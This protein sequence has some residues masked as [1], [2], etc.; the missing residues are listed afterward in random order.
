MVKHSRAFLI[1]DLK[2]YGCELFKATITRCV[3]RP[4]SFVLMP[5]YCVNLKA[6]RYES[7]SLNGIVANKSHHKV[8]TAGKIELI[9]TF[10]ACY[11]YDFMSTTSFLRVYFP[12]L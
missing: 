3:Y 8:R 6:I 5:H 2:N 4:D 9:S 11:F 7:T 1:Y 10:S 12:R